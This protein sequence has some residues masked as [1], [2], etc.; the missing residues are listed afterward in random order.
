MRWPTSIRRSLPGSPWPWKYREGTTAQTNT[1]ADIATYYWVT[2]LKTT[3]TVAT[4]NVPASVV[5]PASWQHLNFA[6][7][8]FGT[9]GTLDS[10]NQSATLASIASGSRRWPTG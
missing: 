5:D 3:G 4:N 9:R 6:A 10:S 1:L 8:S 2:D 7:I